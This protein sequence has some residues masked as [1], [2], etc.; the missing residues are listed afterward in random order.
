MF[1]RLPDQPGTTLESPLFPGPG[2]P[3]KAP[4]R[5]VVGGEG[6]NEILERQD[7]EF[8]PIEPG[9]AV[10][11][12]IEK[13]GEVDRYRITS[14]SEQKV[15]VVIR[16]S[17]LGSWLDSVV[18]VLDRD[19][20]EIAQNDDPGG[21]SNFQ[22]FNGQP[23]PPA[24]SRLSFTLPGNGH[25]YTIE[26]YDRYGDGGAEY[27]YRLETGKA[28][29][30][31]HI[32]LILDPNSNNRRNVFGGRGPNPVLPGS[33][34]SLNLAPGSSTT[35]N[36]LVTGEGPLEPIE[37]EAE[38]L[39]FGVTAD[40]TTIRV[41]S[42]QTSARSLPPTG[43]S[44]T[45]KVAPN[46][47][48][49]LGTLRIV[50]RSKSAQGVPIT[51]LAS[52][53]VIIDR[54]IYS[55]VY[56]P[57]I[58]RELKEM[59]L[60][61]AGDTREAERRPGFV[62][63]PR[64][65]AIALKEVKNPGIL[66]QGDYVDMGLVL[67]PVSPPPGTYMIEG[68]AEGS[69]VGVQT[70]VTEMGGSNL[71]EGEPAAVVRV[72]AAPDAVPGVRKVTLSAEAPEGQADRVGTDGGDSGSDQGP[73]FRDAPGD[74]PGSLGDPGCGGRASK[75]CGGNGRD[76]AGA[77]PRRA[78]RRPTNPGD[79][80]G[81]G[82]NLHPSEARIGLGTSDRA[83]AGRCDRKNP[84]AKRF[85]EGGGGGS[86]DVGRCLCRE[87]V[88][89]RSNTRARRGVQGLSVTARTGLPA[90]ARIRPV[91]SRPCLL[92]RLDSP[93]ESTRT[94]PF[95]ERLVL[96]LPRPFLSARLGWFAAAFLGL[97][98][99]LTVQTAGAEG[100]DSET[101]SILDA[102]KA[103]DLQVS[104]RGAGE[105]R[106]KFKLQNNSTR[107]LNVVIPPGLVASSTTAQGGLGGGG[108]QSMGLGVPTDQPGKFGQYVRKLPSVEAGFRSV[109]LSEPN[110]SAIAVPAG[111]EVELHVPSVCLNFGVP[112]PTPRHEFTL[113]T[114]EDYTPDARAQKALRS[115]AVLGTSQGVAQAVAWNVF[116]GMSYLQ[117]DRL[118]SRV[119]NPWEISLAAR[120]VE[121][122]D[123][124]SPGELVNPAYLREG[125]LLVRVRGDGT[126]GKVASRLNTELHGASLLGLPVQVAEESDLATA[127][128]ASLYL[129]ILLTGD[130]QGVVQAH[131][132]VKGRNAAGRWERLGSLDLGR[133]SE[134]GDVTGEELAVNLDH[135][136]AAGF[137]RVTK[138]RTS[139]GSTTL[140][141][142]NK[143]PFSVEN[144]VVLAGDAEDAPSVTIEALGV[145]PNQSAT[146]RVEA[147]TARV[148]RVET[149][150][151]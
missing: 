50:G 61:V 11:G 117:M 41:A 109:G 136:L 145:G 25:P 151:L 54:P 39:P 108:F 4:M 71:S 111:Q 72:V 62:G 9:Q 52:A 140:K 8:T 13:P 67:D 80:P 58:T 123:A 33:T 78:G 98:P 44:I 7:S 53:E 150:G 60:W 106:V 40:R 79:W 66:L 64:P 30:D 26:V 94:G 74:W 51:R 1:L 92:G 99:W 143:L 28:G 120:F 128:P 149:N 21:N 110:A 57:P 82:Q 83:A 137:V 89:K 17:E 103:G 113:M 96:M 10:C 112:T 43:G 100:L 102:Q 114:V 119:L 55:G 142:L 93:A 124:S 36:F 3:L 12:R 35:L 133:T 77:S 22:P 122:L 27:P 42:M 24:D 34:G 148:E 104:V 81:A 38:G 68:M 19:G 73:G 63:P 76:Q 144:L 18:R 101:V 141:V 121:A 48:A 85:S 88:L 15:S 59:P 134:I 126:L 95:A 129:D 135:A 16:A 87:I 69:G 138:V 23:P 75:G 97:S 146:T 125:R 20:Q 91:S 45:L 56:Q 6:R 49:D 5:V 105:D 107:R 65:I 32:K 47:S 70:L 131:A 46:A 147:P 14:S 37:I 86:T 132:V 90:T 29:P 130:T 116:N 115:L 127:R 2:G 31:F 84:H 139:N 118:A